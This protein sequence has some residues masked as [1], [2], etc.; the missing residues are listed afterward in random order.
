M[1]TKHTNKEESKQ[2]K[3]YSPKCVLLCEDDDNSARGCSCNS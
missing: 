2:K 1:T 3:V